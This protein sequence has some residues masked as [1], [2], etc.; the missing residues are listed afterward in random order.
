MVSVWASARP[1]TKFCKVDQSRRLD[2][3]GVVQLDTKLAWWLEA[4]GGS[5]GLYFRL[6]AW[7]SA[8]CCVFFMLNQEGTCT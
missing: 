4:G 8:K 3:A 1:L 5:G 7:T 6:D 2:P